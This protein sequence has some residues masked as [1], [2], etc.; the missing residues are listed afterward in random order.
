MAAPI[1]KALGNRI[2][3]AL[4]KVKDKAG[5]VISDR[6]KAQENWRNRADNSNVYGSWTDFK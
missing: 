3:P 5:A 6:K 2:R 4:K 1:A